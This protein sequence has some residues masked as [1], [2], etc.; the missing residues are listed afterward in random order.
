MKLDI[1]DIKINYNKTGNGFPIVLIHGLSDNLLFWQD[2]SLKLKNNFKIISMDLRG[3]GQTEIGDENI[4]MELL[5][6]DIYKILKKLNI[7]KSYV[8]GFSLG[9]AI[10]INLTLKYP[11]LVESLVLISS[12]FKVDD[13]LLNSFNKF[14]KSLNKG[15]GEYID[16]I[17][18]HVLPKDIIEISKNEI[19]E[20]KKEKINEL[21]P[22]DLI[23]IIRGIKNFNKENDLDKIKCKTLII[24][25]K[26][27]DLTKPELSYAMNKKI[28]NSK[29]E[30]IEFG[31]HNV[32][33][34]D[35]LSYLNDLIYNFFLQQ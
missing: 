8:L 1:N 30:I 29:L 7:S 16:S 24:V 28:K 26:N 4:S 31:K 22:D 25:S 32:F 20:L 23:K 34:E 35:N 18:N 21:N 12:Y 5:T 15:I 6:D 19:A 27:D 3:H 2:L 33:I 14:E 10:A 11:S 13:N 17:V 9:G